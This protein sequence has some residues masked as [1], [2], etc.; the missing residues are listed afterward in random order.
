MNLENFLKSDIKNG[1]SLSINVENE[2]FLYTEDFDSLLRN[3]EN[4]SFLIEK[5]DINNSNL[6]TLLTL[7]TNENRTNKNFI[8]IIYNDNNDDN[9]ILEIYKI[10]N[11][12]E[13]NYSLIPSSN[14]NVDDYLNILIKFKNIMNEEQNKIRI[15]PLD[16]FISYNQ[17]KILL[18]EFT[19]KNEQNKEKIEKLLNPRPSNYLVEVFFKYKNIDEF[20][21]IKDNFFNLITDD[22]K[23]EEIKKISNLLYIL[24]DNLIKN[25]DL[26]NIYIK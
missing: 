12:I 2:D 26:F 20:N 11:L 25:K 21:I 8:E 4:I 14:C 16:F 24:K 9:E 1:Y 23:K 15:L 18:N 17:M 13:V 6:L 19:E 22:E 3:K 5:K 7:I 10:L